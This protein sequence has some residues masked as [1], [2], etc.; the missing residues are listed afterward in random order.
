ML[1]R[2]KVSGFKNLVNVDFHFGAFTCVAGPNGVGKSNLFDAITF[3]SLLADKPFVEAARRV[4]GGDDLRSLFHN[5]DEG[6]MSIFAEMLIPKDGEDEFGQPAEASATFLTY[7][8]ELAL[9]QAHDGTSSGA[10]IRL[11]K[12]EL[13]YITR[14]DA[15]SRLKFP[16]T[17][18]WRDSVVRTARTT[19]FIRTEESTV[20]GAIVRLQSDRMQGTDK[21]QRGGG[22]A[23]GYAAATLPRTVLSSAQNA[24]E[25][26]TAVIVRQEMRQ[27]RQ[28]QLEPTSLRQ[29]DDFEAESRLD[30]S[31]R[32]IPAVLSRLAGGTAGSDSEVCVRLANSLMGLVEGVRGVRVDRD[33]S[34]RSLRFM[35]KDKSGLELPAGSLSDGTLRFVALSL[36]D[37]DPVNLGLICLEEPENGIHPQRV[38]AMLQ[39]LYRIACDTTLPAGETNPLRQIAISTHSP[40]VFG[41]VHRGDVAFAVPHSYREHDARVRGVEFMG[42]RGSWRDGVDGKAIGDGDAMTFLQ[43]QPSVPAPVETSVSVSGQFFKDQLPLFLPAAELP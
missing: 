6:R 41:N 40:I 30:A 24:E 23:L 22:K 11:T 31:G 16:H 14:K 38:N 43:G 12:E 8:L 25:S 29:V 33:E 37:L 2:L 32:H 39:L 19:S 15:R 9:E 3:L 36:I 27:W 10:R 17:K 20:R 34:R 4:R 28:L 42:L 1:T 7:E 5:P 35:M 18:A 26:R 13:T 21:T